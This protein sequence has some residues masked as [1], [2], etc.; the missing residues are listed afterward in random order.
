M[1]SLLEYVFYELWKPAHGIDRILRLKAAAEAV[2]GVYE[3]YP[4][5]AGRVHIPLG[6]SHVN[7]LFKP[8]PF[9]YKLYIVALVKARAAYALDIPDI[10]RRFMI[11]DW[12]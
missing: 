12:I 7:G 8:V 11:K 4:R 10:G 2:S 5:M 3:G 1:T 9:D 6:V